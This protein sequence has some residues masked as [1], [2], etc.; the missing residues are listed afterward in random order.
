MKKKL[1]A[2][3]LALGVFASTG[4]IGVQAS[5]ATIPSNTSISS[6]LAF[7]SMSIYPETLS[8]GNVKISWD[9]ISGASY[10]LINVINQDTNTCIWPDTNRRTNS[11]N[12]PLSGIDL[13]NSRGMSPQSTFKVWVGAYNSNGALIGSGITYFLY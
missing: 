11:T 8:T 2:L 4:L 9:R 12:Y 3:T 5:A 7:S 1:L 6:T 10:Y 13:S